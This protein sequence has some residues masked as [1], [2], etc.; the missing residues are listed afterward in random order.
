MPTSESLAF[1]SHCKYYSS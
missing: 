1:I